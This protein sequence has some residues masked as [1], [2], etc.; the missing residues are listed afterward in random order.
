MKTHMKR[1][2]VVS[3]HYSDTHVSHMIALAKLLQVL[4]YAVAFIHDEKYLP[5]AAFSAI[6]KAMS[7]RRYYS[8]PG[9]QPFDLAIFCNSATQNHSLVRTL[10]ARQT[11][12][13]Y[14]FHEPEP[15]WSFSVLK[16]EGWT[17][18]GRFVLSTL[19]SIK[20]VRACSG[21]I[22]CSLCGQALYKQYYQRFNSNVHVMPLLFD[23]EIGDDLFERMRNSKRSFGFVGTACRAHGFDVFVT[24]AKYAIRNGSAIPFTIAT[25]VDLTS[26]LRA[27]RELARLV[28]DGKI[29]LQHGQKLSNDEINQYYLECFCIWNVY[30]RSTQ[31][32]V[33]PRAYMAGSLVLASRIGSFP[34]FVDE[35][36]TGEFVDSDD[37]PESILEVV[38]GMRARSIH[39]VDGCRRKFMDTF[40]YG[41][42]RGSLAEMIAGTSTRTHLHVTDIDHHSGL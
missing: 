7:V 18:T 6:G 5:F 37:N 15:L 19:F 35:G 17:K 12:V 2:A 4:G 40:Y 24:L 39:Y 3:L 23:D 25:S 34:E 16:S 1:A 11:T 20:T 32:G 13:L 9:I 33:L 36:V 14:V 10:R 41:A 30:R 28:N 27:D 29:R 31:S 38:E 21:V 26:V 22:V 42:N 8:N